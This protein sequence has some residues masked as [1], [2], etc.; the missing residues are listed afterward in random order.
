EL[1]QRVD[2]PHG[3]ER[4]THEL[5]EG[6]ASAVA[7]G[8]ESEGE[9]IC[10]SRFVGHRFSA[11]SHGRANVVRARRAVAYDNAN[12]DL[13]WRGFLCAG[14]GTWPVLGAA[15]ARG[16]TGADAWLRYERIADPA[17]RAA[18]EP[19]PAVVVAIGDGLVLRAARD[20]I[21][22]GVASMLDRR[23]NPLPQVPDAAAALVLGTA[24]AGLRLWPDAGGP[25][26]LRAGG[27]WIGWVSR[28]RKSHASLVVSGGSERGVLYGAFA[29]L[30]RVA[31]HQPIVGPAE[32]DEPAAPL[33]W[34][35]EWNNLDGSIERGYAGRSIFFANDR[36]VA[37]LTR[38]REY[39]RLL[40]S[41]GINACAVNNV[42]ADVR[43][44][45]DEFIPDLVRLAGAFRPFGVGL[46][47][48]IDFSS[49]E[50]VGGLDTFDPLDARVAA[51]WK[52]R[53]DALYRAIPDLAGL[54]LKA[55]SEG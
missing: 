39:A 42:N 46:A 14:L 22:R 6:I 51:F 15:R 23:L 49:P 10:G 28:G 29:L 13:T 26:D 20:E 52:A 36:V 43:V 19:L 25:A 48:A 18:Y 24:P 47:V 17:M 50:R 3:I 16:E 37:D 7:D 32:R 31:L 55:D 34:V 54:V 35:N 44:I 4:R 27:F 21:V 5:A 8:P 12:M 2:R 53:V 9:A 11:R 1:G 45:T 30:R 38:A 33:R 41:V 40:A